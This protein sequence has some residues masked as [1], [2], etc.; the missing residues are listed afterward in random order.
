MLKKLLIATGVLAT[1]LLVAGWLL[2]DVFVYPGEDPHSGRTALVNGQFI[3]MTS[4]DPRI[5]HDRAMLVEDGTIGAF[6][7]SEALP[8]DVRR[9]DLTGGYA[10]PGLFDMHVHLGGIP[11]VEG[12]SVPGMILEFMRGF[13][14]ARKKFL[15]H[16]VTT[17]ASLGDGHPQGVQ[18]RDDIGSGKLAGPRLLVA[19]PMLTAPDGHPVS[20]IFEGNERAIEGATRQLDDPDEARAVVD[21]LVEE[22]VDLIKVIYTA[23]R[24]GT[25]PRMQYDVLKA[26]VD[27]AH[28]RGTRVVVHTDS[29]S[30]V[31][32]ALRAG[33]DGQEH[34]ALDLGE[35][36]D[37]LL[38]R[39]ADQ[40]VVIVPTLTVIRDRVV[41]DGSA[42]V[43]D[44]FSRWL[45]HD[46]PVALGTDAGNLP[47]GESVYDEIGLLVEAG[48]TPYEALETATIGSARHAGLDDI[49]GTLEPGKHAD[50]VVFDENPLDRIDSLGL[51]RMVFKEG[52]LMIDRR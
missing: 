1:L 18:L 22:G 43:A 42:S 48:M 11:A 30:E 15:D 17:V 36:A 45:D 27:R 28:R 38:E 31:E 5:V 10:V 41:D 4:D 39:L 46:I 44:T 19:G 3:T 25:L 47:A 49:L 16:G 21:R 40:E 52:T 50:V 9:V 29:R 7:D 32:D 2:L 51:P 20:T 6:V 8:D 13:P 24:S 35:D 26:I 37:Q 33:A 14:S 34:L 23:G 12:A